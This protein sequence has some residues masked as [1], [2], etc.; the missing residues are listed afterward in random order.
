MKLSHR[1]IVGLAAAGALA[2]IGQAPAQADSGVQIGV[3]TCDES[4]GWG[5]VLGSSHDLHC[6]YQPTSGDMER[7]TGSID[8]LG[9]DIGY[10]GAGILVWQVW[11]P[12]AQMKP[13]SLEGTYGGVQ[14]SAA[15]G[16]GVGANVLV[17]GSNNAF[18]LQP[19]SVEGQTG[20]NLAAGVGQITLH[21][22]P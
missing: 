9:V 12:A 4:S 17:G 19:V 22:A 11:S 8:K 5:L 7:Y 15:V 21:Y 13:G 14:A 1:M 10:R 16:G 6:T 20:L 18:S 3:L 2:L